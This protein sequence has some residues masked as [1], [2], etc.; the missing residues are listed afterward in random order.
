MLT[1]NLQIRGKRKSIFV[2]V[3]VR[4]LKVKHTTN[5]NIVLI[6]VSKITNIKN[7]LKNINKITLWLNLL[8]GNRS[9]RN[10][11]DIFLKNLIINAVNVAGIK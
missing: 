6:S 3:V 4:K 5:A 10:Y 1:K 11:A 2:F 9:L 8:H 7:G